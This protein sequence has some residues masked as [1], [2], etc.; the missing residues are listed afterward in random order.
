MASVKNPENWGS[1]E[2][3]VRAAPQNVA[4]D[5][6]WCSVIGMWLTLPF[7]IIYGAIA[8]SCQCLYRSI[9]FAAANAA[10]KG[11]P[12]WLAHVGWRYAFA[13]LIALIRNGKSRLG[14]FL[15]EREVFGGDYFWQGEGVWTTTY[16][17]CDEICRSEQRRV[18]A[19]ACIR[20]CTPDLFSSGLLIF[21][22]NE[23]GA[24][25]EWGAFRAA[26]HNLFL[27]T[28][29]AYYQERKAQ[30][31]EK[32][33][34]D[35]P[36]SGAKLAALTDDK[37]FLQAMVC[38]CLFFMMFGVWVTTEEA[39]VLSRWR[40]YAKFFVLNRLI[41]RLAFNKGIKKV[42]QLRIDTVQIVEKY[43]LQE[44]FVKMNDN[45]PAKYRRTPVVRLCDE[46]LYGLGFAGI[47]GTCACVE[48]VTK[49]LQLKTGE[50]PAKDV[51]FRKF[52][53]TDA[54]VAAYKE[55]GDAFIRE[56]CRLD[57]PVTSATSSLKADTVFNLGK[58]LTLK[59]GMLQQ[60][61]LSLANRDPLIFPAPKV[62]D[63]SRDN[64]NLALTWNGALV[65][66]VER[67]YPRICPG[68]YLSMDVCRAIVDFGLSVPGPGP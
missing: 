57:P 9:S 15:W 27:D 44:V 63:P 42:Q 13:G 16:A 10:L 59:A 17:Q 45:L 18:Q 33:A 65:E 25:S 26:F 38:K 19:F 47:G 30:L 62:F 55:D 34:S 2:K 41:Q 48:S 21:L 67:K 28:G 66:D 50:V 49:F 46:V 1:I 29:A 4:P 11:R 56:T 68:R 43:G 20:A 32:L 8:G 24:D 23:G 40:Q 54:M 51:D 14:L 64:L 39:Q 61:T 52:K 6:S 5:E 35:W 3:V 60:Y 12:C 36:S 58:E 22:S 31:R 53:T 7:N 37:Q